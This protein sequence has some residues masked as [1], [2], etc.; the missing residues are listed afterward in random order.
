MK[1]LKTNNVLVLAL[2]LFLSCLSP[3]NKES[4]ALAAR[5]G[6]MDIQLQY[7]DSTIIGELYSL[8]ARVLKQILIKELV[9]LEAKER[10]I[11]VNELK[12]IE[13][14]SKSKFPA[15]EKIEEFKSINQSINWDEKEVERI[16]NEILQQERKDEFEKYLLEKYKPDI[17][18][19]P[20]HSG[21]IS[22]ERLLTFS[23]DGKE[24]ENE[25]ILVFDFDC[26]SCTDVL[27]KFKHL[28]KKY[29]NVA[30]FKLIYLTANYGLPGKALMAAHRQGIETI[31]FERM[32]VTDQDIHEHDFYHDFVSKFSSNPDGFNIDFASTEILK[33][34]LI[35]RDLLFSQGVFSTPVFI[36][37]GFL[38]DHEETKDILE[39]LIRQQFLT[40]IN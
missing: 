27:L 3:E 36:V 9:I 15:D 19:F 6:N 25:I 35:T 13:I 20:P 38:Y 2:F 34:L 17:F 14:V 40:N 16:L 12:E 29:T 1:K 7:V 5:I 32:L 39:A 18:L 8:R 37:N 24:N 4:E 22:T 26:M 31:L 23:F 28:A 30:S 21:S 11:S 10:N 33:D